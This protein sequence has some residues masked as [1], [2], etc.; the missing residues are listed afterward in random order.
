MDDGDIGS[1]APRRSQI[2]FSSVVFGR[3]PWGWHR[4]EGMRLN[5][6]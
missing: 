6:P 3:F 2:R 1:E 5:M 4:H